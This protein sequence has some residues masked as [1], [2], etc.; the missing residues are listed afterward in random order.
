MRS[1]IVN[2]LNQHAEIKNIGNLL[3]EMPALLA[4]DAF[5]PIVF[6]LRLPSALQLS[7]RIKWISEIFTFKSE[8]FQVIYDGKLLMISAPCSL[9]ERPMGIIDARD[10]FIDMLKPI[11]SPRRIAP[12]VTHNCFVIT[13]S[14][15]T[16]PESKDVY[17]QV[18]KEAP[19]AEVSKE[20]YLAIGYSMK[21]FYGTCRI[22]EDIEKELKNKFVENQESLFKNLK[23]L[24]KYRWNNFFQRKKAIGNVKKHIIQ[25][26][27]MLA[28]YPSRMQELR[29]S[30]EFVRREMKEDALFREFM[31]KTDWLEYAD[32]KQVDTE[33]ITKIIDYAHR[34]METHKLTASETRAAM[35]G[36]LAGASATLLLTY[37]LSLFG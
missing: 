14:E 36:G 10:R 15:G 27:E 31:E 19:I 29:E 9:E 11:T 28:K 2:I 3:E 8:E 18:A 17:V 16:K 1:K 35:M 7:K 4:M 33:T 24:E 34:E 12:C 21:T 26:L 6:T 37:L 22:S 23:D 20:L 13:S 32:T 25:M 30:I 5:N